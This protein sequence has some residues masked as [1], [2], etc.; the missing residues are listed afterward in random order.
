M[1]M[2]PVTLLIIFVMTCIYINID[3]I[4]AFQEKRWRGGPADLCY[5]VSFVSLV[6]LV[7]LWQ[8]F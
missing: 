7:I 2:I 6:V 8:F 4:P 5:C 3:Q 1:I